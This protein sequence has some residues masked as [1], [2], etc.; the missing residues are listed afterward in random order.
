[1]MKVMIFLL[2]EFNFLV[3]IYPGS[4]KLIEPPIHNHNTT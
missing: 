2:Q 4:L 3:D 1:L